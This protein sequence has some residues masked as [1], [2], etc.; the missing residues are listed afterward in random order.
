MEFLGVTEATSSINKIDGVLGLSP[1]SSF[2]SYLVGSEQYPP[3]VT[4]FLGELGK[5]GP[6]KSS[7]VFGCSE[8]KKDQH[9]NEIKEKFH[10]FETS[11]LNWEIGVGSVKLGS[12]S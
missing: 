7:A 11:E 2:I 6:G 3:E 9:G 10:N 8:P 12:F 4:L 1:K 5:G